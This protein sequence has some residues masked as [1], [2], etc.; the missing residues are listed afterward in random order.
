VIDLAGAIFGQSV[1][2]LIRDVLHLV[3]DDLPNR[4]VVE[5]WARAHCRLGFIDGQF[6]KPVLEAKALSEFMQF[7]SADEPPIGSGP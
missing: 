2:D 7:A 3:R 4:P 1:E 6:S 5:V